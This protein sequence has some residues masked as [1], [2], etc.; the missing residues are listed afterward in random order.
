MGFVITSGER[1]L[2]HED[3]LEAGA[4]AATGFAAAGLAEGDAVALLLRNDIAM[5]VAMQGAGLAGC[6]AAPINW[7]NAPEETGYVLA[8]ADA[9]LLVAHADLLAGLDGFIPQDC[10]VLVVETPPEIGDAYAVPPEA[11]RLPPGATDWSQWLSGHAPRTA[12]PAPSRGSMI[13]TSGTTG[14][15][16]GVRRAPA[17]EAQQQEFLRMAM[18]GFGIRQGCTALMTGPMYHSAPSAYARVVL[19]VGGN[20]HLMSR[21]DA[22]GL[23]ALIEKLHVTHMHMVPTMFHRLLALPEEVRRRYDVSSLEFVIHGAAPCPAESKRRML[24]WWGPVIYEYY[25][26]T[27][28]GLVTQATPADALAKPGSV[29]RVWP[30][31]Q[32]R[33]LDDEG[34]PLPP[35]QEGEV[36]MSIAML[37]DFTYNRRDD[38][39]AEIER[40][41]FLTN[42]DVGY[43]DEDGYL[44]LCD[45]KRDMVISGGVNIYPAEIEAVLATMPGVADCAV[46]GIPDEQYGEAV[47]AAILPAAGAELTEAGVRAFLA[48]HLAGYKLPRL[49]TFHAEL[50]RED[51]G[52]IFK[53][54][55]REPYWAG[56][57]RRI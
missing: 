7:H 42:G 5:L 8:D 12:A 33:I 45:R 10:R 2:A 51:S 32:V 50:P 35:G 57:G 46:F 27:E 53:R 17:N 9:G 16:K 49:V 26:S 23:L 28:L 29:G 43:L 30:E 24:E 41:G 19:G 15:P 1:S 37:T 39:R 18:R 14:R 38:A 11:R 25:G 22:E 13:Y 40:D 31:R 4:R 6:Y 47:A 21:F 34:R 3:Y 20:L 48:P 52:K 36:Y 54:K 56:R 55:L 44:F